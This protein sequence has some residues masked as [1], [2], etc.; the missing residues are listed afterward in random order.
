MSNLA[1][2]SSSLLHVFQSLPKRGFDAIRVK[3]NPDARRGVYAFEVS[4]E[5]VEQLLDYVHHQRN[6]SPLVEA[7]TFY[8]ID[9]DWVVRF[10][11]QVKDERFVDALHTHVMS[12]TVLLCARVYAGANA[13]KVLREEED[14]GVTWCAVNTVQS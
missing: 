6:I 1:H 10:D 12:D 3:C 14:V 5:E 4:S 2:L 8:P 9:N 13:T 11:E 7:M